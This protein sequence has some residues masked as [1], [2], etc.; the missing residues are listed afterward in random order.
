MK[1][2]NKRK[3]RKKKKGK[4]KNTKSTKCNSKESKK[5]Y[6]KHNANFNNKKYIIAVYH[7]IQQVKTCIHL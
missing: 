2:K 5:S 1:K 6:A 3:K 4:E 7:R